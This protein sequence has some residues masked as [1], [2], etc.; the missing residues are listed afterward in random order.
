MGEPYREKAERPPIPAALRRWYT[1][2]G[3][4]EKGPFDAEVLAS[5]LEGG[6][7]KTTTLVRAEDGTEWQRITDVKALVPKPPP[8]ALPADFDERRHGM[9]AQLGTFG[10]GFAAGFF[11]GLI[12]LLIVL[13]VAKGEATKRGARIGFGCQIAAGIL[14]RIVAAAG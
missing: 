8:A 5:S 3:D 7:I 13:A 11:G 6:R 2:N 14:L 9:P 10:G 1:K 4:V 12:G